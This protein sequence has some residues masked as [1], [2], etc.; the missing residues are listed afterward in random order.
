MLIKDSVI[1]I[2]GAS[3]GIAL[4]TAMAAAKLGARLVLA[5]RRRPALDQAVLQ[6]EECGGEAIAVPTDVTRREDVLSLEKA[7]VAKFGRIDAWVNAAAAAA[8][9]RFDEIP[10][11]VFKQVLETN[12]LGY[13]YCSRSAVARFRQQEA[14]I[15]VNVSSMVAEGGQAFATPY[16]MSKF[17][18]RGLTLSLDQELRDYPHIHACS[19]LPGVVDTP[20]FKHAANYMGKRVKP[21]HPMLS[22]EQVADTILDVVERPRRETYAGLSGRILGT[23]AHLTPELHDLAMKLFV[24]HDH[25]LNEDI[26]ATEGNIFTPMGDDAMARGGWSGHNPLTPGQKV[27]ERGKN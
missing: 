26:D 17:A 12:V 14:G 16:V 25:F 20:I 4:A 8:Y 7:A 5:A 19:V 10:V 2:T 11:E 9:G 1:V 6:C 27:S 3:S 23:A 21:P 15:L 18:Q 24:E 13:Y 22:A